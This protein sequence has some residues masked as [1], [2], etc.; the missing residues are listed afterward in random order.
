MADGAIGY[1]TLPI[2]PSMAGFGPALAAGTAGPAVAAGKGAGAGFTAGFVSFL[3]PV[4]IAA[5]VVVAFKGLYEIGGIMDTVT[6][7]IRV[8]TGAQGA[9]LDG[10]VTN[11]QNVGNRIP[12]TLEDIGDAVSGVTQRLGYTGPVLEGFTARLL[13][14]G[15]LQ[16]TPVPINDLSS[17]LNG[18]RVPAEQANGVL[19]QL[20]RVSQATGVPVAQLSTSL[21][22]QGAVL[23]QLG[24]SLGSSAALLATLDKAGVNANQ[25]VKSL[26]AGM[27]K[28]AKDGEEPAVAFDRVIGELQGYVDT[29]Q[30][31]AALDL[32]GTIFGTRGAAQFISA[33]ESGQVNLADLRAGVF[34][35][36]DTILVA[37]AQTR[38]FDENLQILQNNLTTRLAPAGEA[39]FGL[40]NT[41]FTA[42]TNFVLGL[43]PLGDIFAPALAVVTPLAQTVG[44]ILVD[45]FGQV[46]AAISPLIPGLLQ[47]WTTASP[48]MIVLQAL[49][50]VLP[51]LSSLFGQLVGVVAQLASTILPVLIPVITQVA[52]ILGGLLA[53]V[54]PIVIGF[55][56]QMAP[57]F[58]QLVGVIGTLAAAVLPVL[59]PIL[60]QVAGIFGGVLAAVLPIVAQ[61]ISALVPIVLSLVEALLPVITAVLGL[62]SPLLALLEPIIALIGP[63]LTPLIDLLVMLIGTALQPLMVAFQAVLPPI[64]DIVSTIAG[65][66]L[67]IIGAVTQILGGL[68]NFLVGV[69][70]GNWSQAW[71]GIVDIFSGIWNGIVGILKGVLNTAIAVINGIISGI[72]S[73]AGAISDATGGAISFSIPKIPQLATG[74]DVAARRG[75][76][77]ALLGE[78]GQAETVTNLG[79]TNRAL[80][81]ATALANRALSGS[82]GVDVQT[83]TEALT[84]ALRA[85]FEEMDPTDLSADTIDRLARALAALLRVQNRQG[86]PVNA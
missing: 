74:A 57:I 76:T 17:A 78:G 73:V 64:I 18:F 34:E 51:M 36:G 70:T 8:N 2:I 66:L 45:A 80:E 49:T 22:N 79:T 1:A 65:A 60:T 83:L 72:N 31:A 20:F 11:V 38:D 69:F 86:G 4:A 63:L 15:R 61:L 47:L 77:L 3:G 23:G 19:D 56:L 33:L 55:L 29:G 58:A 85:V 46:W 13:E 39:V 42:L 16:G 40:F 30:T 50:P 32:A 84:A 28:L 41:G 43:P 67:P 9:A 62:I 75:G 12:A 26:S 5:A 21:S 6:D 37:A 35:T 10:L 54:L 52:G 44:G 71:Q 82:G 14:V 48:V 81:A 68:I 25:V 7:G 53:Q 59:V 27:V 24:F